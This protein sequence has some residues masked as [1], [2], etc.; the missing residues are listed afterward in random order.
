MERQEVVS[1]FHAKRVILRMSVIH[2][3]SHEKR[4]VIG[5]P[6]PKLQKEK[7]LQIIKQKLPMESKSLL[8]RLGTATSVFSME[9]IDN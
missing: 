9:D 8:Y 7:S 2:S 6:S 5:M 1:I 4:A 3:P